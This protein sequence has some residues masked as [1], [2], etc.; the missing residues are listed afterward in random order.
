ME[1]RGCNQWQTAAN[2]AA[3]ERAKTSENRCCGLPPFA[4]DVHGK[5]GST[6]RVPYEIAARRRFFV[7]TNLLHVERAVGMEPFM[8][9]SGRA[10]RLKPFRR[11]TPERRGNAADGRDL[12][13]AQPWL[14]PLSFSEGELAHANGPA[15]PHRLHSLPRS[16]IRRATRLSQALELEAA[17]RLSGEWRPLRHRGQSGAH[18]LASSHARNDSWKRRRRAIKCTGDELCTDPRWGARTASRH[19]QWCTSATG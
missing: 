10:R 7:Q 18:R 11:S 2:A 19:G 13:R 16:A 6:V 3:P 9:P 15:E 17:E 5:E 14:R 8:E 1:P 4:R 12:R